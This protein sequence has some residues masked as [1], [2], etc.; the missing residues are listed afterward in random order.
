MQHINLP[1]N[2][3]FFKIL[4]SFLICKIS[5]YQNLQYYLYCVYATTDYQC[6]F[7]CLHLLF[8][9]D[10]TK[11]DEIDDKDGLPNN[12]TESKEKNRVNV[13]TYISDNQ[14][15]HLHDTMCCSIFNSCHF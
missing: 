11:D 1:I 2:I 7:D 9:Q 5:T 12:A 10:L 14:N 13:P 6:F 8:D 3:G 15:S 4:V